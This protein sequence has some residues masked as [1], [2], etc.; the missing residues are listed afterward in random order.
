MFDPKGHKPKSGGFTATTRPGICALVVY[1]VFSRG[2][3]NNNKQF[4]KV[5]YRQLAGPQPD[6][7]FIDAIFLSR[8]SL[9]KLGNLCAAVGHED[10]FD[11]SIDADLLGA[12]GRR[13]FIARV[14][15]DTVFEQKFAKLGHIAT[16]PTAARE[17]NPLLVP[18]M[19]AYIL[20]QAKRSSSDGYDPFAPD[21]PRGR[22]S[23]QHR[24]SF[25]DD[26]PMAGE[27]GQL[28]GDEEDNIPF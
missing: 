21:E 17:E 10:A 12:I 18:A 15:I 20:E 19:D 6:S 26:S 23:D 7:V 4:V 2:K 27:D 16:D 1:K 9:W 24:D 22:R 13:P 25:F 5:H 11:P 8:E 3:S 14:D 28:V